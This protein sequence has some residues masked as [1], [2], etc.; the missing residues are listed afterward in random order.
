MRTR[1]NH[2]TQHGPETPV[3]EL[4]PLSRDSAL[5]ALREVFEAMSP[6]ARYMRYHSATPRLT[7]SLERALADVDG[8]RHSAWQ[9]VE[10]GRRVGLVRIIET[11]DETAELAVEVA[12][13]HTGRGIGT[14]LVAAALRHAAERR[15][16]AVRVVVHPENRPAVRLFRSHSARFRF[17][18]SVLEGVIPVSEV[19]PPD[20]R[21]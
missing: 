11:G 5:D 20:F 6:S 4:E 2:T 3:I 15:L 12:D 19:A 7:K 18:D 21:R 14:A 8:E 9:A 16:T 13:D 17:A 10:R 1:T